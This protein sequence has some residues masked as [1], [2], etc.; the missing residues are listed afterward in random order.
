MMD[1]AGIIM[2]FFFYDD[3]AQIWSGD[4]VGPEERDLIMASMLPVLNANPLP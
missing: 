3:S 4:T 2:Y 1:N